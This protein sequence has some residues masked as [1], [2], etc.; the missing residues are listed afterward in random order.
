MAVVLLDEY[1]KERKG[2]IDPSQQLV[3]CKS[4]I[5]TSG[6]EDIFDVLGPCIVPMPGS[7]FSPELLKQNMK[8]MQ[9]LI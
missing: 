4:C 2:L 9:V 8:D 1:K 7:C 3:F 5:P 6:H